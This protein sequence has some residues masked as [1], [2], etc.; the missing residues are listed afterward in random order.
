VFSHR[1]LIVYTF[2]HN[3][4][5]ISVLALNIQN[6]HRPEEG[7]DLF[8]HKRDCISVLALNIQN[9]HRPEEGNDVFSHKRDCISV[10]ALNSQN[11][12]RPEERNDVFYHRTV[13]V[14]QF[15]LKR[16][17]IYQF[18]HITVKII[19]D[20]KREIMCFLITAIVTDRER[21]IMRFLRWY[22]CMEERERER[23]RN[24]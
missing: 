11:Y 7:N 20:Q 12:H 10:L 15:C 18:W 6:C 5:C 16:D 23:E 1:T 8:S 13:I 21:E 19:T 9:C 24:I 4:D 3:R 14:Y 2:S 22:M 17:C